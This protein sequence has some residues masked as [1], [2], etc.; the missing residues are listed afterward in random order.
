MMTTTEERKARQ[1]ANNILQ[2]VSRRYHDGLALDE[3]S[4]ALTAN[5][6][7]DLEPAIYCGRDGSIHEQV[8]ER[9]WISMQWHKMESGSYEVNTYLS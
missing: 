6:F 9:T 4:S 5:G 7:N 1:R 3:I 8:G 2:G